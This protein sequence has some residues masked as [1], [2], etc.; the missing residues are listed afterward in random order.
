[1][2]IATRSAHFPGDFKIPLPYEIGPNTNSSY[3]FRP[4]WQANDHTGFLTVVQMRIVESL[5]SGTVPNVITVTPWAKRIDIGFRDDETPE[6]AQACIEIVA[7]VL[8]LPVETWRFKDR[9][10]LWETLKT[11][12]TLDADD[13]EVIR[14]Y[15]TTGI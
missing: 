12:Q 2:L 4:N 5:L 13:R 6:Q 7:Q 8:G 10:V 14:L 3:N 15:M 11:I 1:M 9:S